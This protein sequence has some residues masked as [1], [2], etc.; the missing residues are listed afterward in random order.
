MIC[1]NVFAYGYCDECECY[2]E[3]CD[4]C[5]SRLSEEPEPANTSLRGPWWI[6]GPDAGG[7]ER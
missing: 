5:T 3:A 1:E 4:G 6:S 7:E 2:E